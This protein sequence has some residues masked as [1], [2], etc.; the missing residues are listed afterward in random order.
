MTISDVASPAVTRSQ[1]LSRLI[2]NPVLPFSPFLRLTGIWEEDKM[3]R[4]S[5]GMMTLLDVVI[6][7]DVQVVV[8]TGGKTL[9]VI[10]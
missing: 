10:M 9:K 8:E 5:F 4:L 1:T 2:I 7:K 3:K 6:G